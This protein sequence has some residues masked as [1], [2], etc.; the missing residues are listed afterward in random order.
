MRLLMSVLVALTAATTAGAMTSARGAVL[1]AHPPVVVPRANGFFDYMLVD[2]ERRRLI[3]SHTGSQS[4]AFID[5][6]SG[7]LQ[8]QLYIGTTHG[9]AIDAHDERYYIGTSGATH[10]IAV[11][12]RRTLRLVATISMPV[13]IDALTFDDRRGMLY[14]DEDNGDT[15]WVIAARTN[16]VVARIRTPQDSDKADYDHA[17]DRF[18]QNFTTINA[19]LVIDPQ[20]HAT[21]ARWSTLPARKPH[22]L[23]VDSKAGIVYAAGVNGALVALDIHTGRRVA[24]AAITKNVDQIALD[25]RR[26][27]LYCAS[28]DGQLSVVDVRTPH[29]ALIATIAV[30]RGAH[31]V[32]LD[33]QTGA[34]WLSY[35]TE[36]DDYVM[37]L[38]P[39]P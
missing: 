37:R 17:T 35:G 11:V 4:V 1:E 21:L 34:V 15:I 8:R 22:G 18:Y 16:Q 30:P 38:T 9:I 25:T 27:R 20:S 36:H 33:P 19:M 23:A 31:T 12:D 28:G 6:A 10:I 39:S 32:A 14:A 26:R 24:T 3:V 13:P 5:V 29:I 7:K 2:A